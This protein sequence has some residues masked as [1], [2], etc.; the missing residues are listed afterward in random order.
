MQKKVIKRKKRQ[1][2]ARRLPFLLSLFLTIY[3]YMNFSLTL[4]AQD[5]CS[6]RLEVQTIAARCQADGEIICHL[7]DTAGQHLEQIRYSYIPVVGNDSILKTTQSHVNQM[8]PGRYIVSVSALCRTGLGHEDAY[9]IVTDSITDV[10][11]GSTYSI[12]TNGVQ[13]NIFTKEHPFGIIPS[14]ACEPTG[15]VQLVLQKGSF[16]YTVNIWKTTSTDTLFYKTIVFDTLQNFGNDPNRSDYKHYYTIDSLAAGTYMMRCHDGCGY[17][18]P[19]IYASIPEAHLT[20]DVHDFLLRNSSG[21]HDSRNIIVF[22]DSIRANLIINNPSYYYYHNPLAPTFEYRFIN[23]TLS[24]DLDTTAWLPLPNIPINGALYLKDTLSQLSSY[25]ECWMKNITLQYRV[26]SCPD[27]IWSSTYTIYPQGRNARYNDPDYTYESMTPTYFDNCYLYS[28]SQSFTKINNRFLF[29]HHMIQFGAKTDSLMVYNDKAYSECGKIL[30]ITIGMS[31]H[32]YITLPVIRRIYD[33]ETNEVISID[34]AFD[35]S[36]QYEWM[37]YYTQEEH[38]NN[39][40]LIAEITDFHGNPL[41]AEKFMSLIDTSHHGID[42]FRITYD[43]EAFDTQEHY[44]AGNPRSVGLTQMCNDF[45]IGSTYSYIGDTI[46]LIESPENNRYNITAY[47][48]RYM[49]F[50]VERDRFDNLADIGFYRNIYNSVF[51]HPA[52]RMS[53][54]DLPSGEYVWV[55]YHACDRPN[56]TIRQQVV[57]TETPTISEAPQYEIIEECTQLKIIPTAG[58]YTNDGVALETYFQAHIGE[59]FQHSLNSV[60][61]GDTIIIGTPGEY[62][63]TMYALPRNNA[64]LLSDNPCFHIDTLIQ[65]DARTI[66]FDYLLSYVCNEFDSIGFVRA[67]GKYG[68]TPHTYTLY[69]APN[70]EGNI[71]GQNHTG[72]F[73]DLPIHYGQVLSI[74]MRDQCHAHFLTNFIVSDMESI[75]KAWM[76]DDVR[77]TT[78]IEGDTCR[79][80]SISMGDATYHWSGPNEYVHDT[81]NSQFVIPRNE[82]TAGF[83]YVTIEGSGCSVIRDSVH[84]DVIKAPYIY[85]EQDTLVCPGETIQIVATAEGTDDIGYTLIKETFAGIERFDFEHRTNGQKDTLAITIVEKTRFYIAQVSDAR[86]TYSATSDTVVANIRGESILASLHSINDSVCKGEDAQL[87]AVSDALPPYTIQW[88]STNGSQILQSDSILHPGQRSTFHLSNIEQ[89]TA[90]RVQLHATG[91]C[92]FDRGI[93]GHTTMKTG[94]MTIPENEVYRFYDSGGPSRSYPF[95]EN[96]ILTF[97]ASDSTATLTMRFEQ[98]DCSDATG[99]D[100]TDVL[101]IFDGDTI[102]DTPLHTLRGKIDTDHLP[103]ISSSTGSITCWFLSNHTPDNNPMSYNGW[104]AT[105]RSSSFSDASTITLEEEAR[106]VVR[107]TSSDTTFR[108]EIDE[109]ELPF[110]WDGITFSHADTVTEYRTTQ[111]GCDS[112]VRHILNVKVVPACPN[113][114]DYDGNEYVSIRI[115]RYCW[116]QTNLK[117]THYS[118]GRAIPNVMGYFAEEHADSTQNI[119]IFGRLYDWYAAVDT[120]RIDRLASGHKQGICPE[121]WYLPNEEQYEELGEFGILAIRSP[122]YWIT[123]AGNNSTGFSSLPAGYYNG[124]RHRFENLLGE[125]YYWADSD[126]ISSESASHFHTFLACDTL[127]KQQSSKENG[128]SIRCIYDE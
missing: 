72:D 61:L 11:V 37:S 19:Q 46:R 90:V 112:I 49:H 126:L 23:P 48:D 83:Y 9:V 38:R 51:A 122:Y 47:A 4:Q 34:T 111:N 26:R 53:S 116:T 2:E 78:L 1:K 124:L 94:N 32:S 80:Y 121:G 16:P 119:L 18:M 45:I 50:V 88:L 66:E 105:V 110:L 86:C 117:S 115:G 70:G 64:S 118:D 91:T 40:F 41:I 60:Q 36:N 43:W 21:I 89:D 58:G 33:V 107:G 85:L 3:C 28:F 31:M 54:N 65:W 44:C 81:Q 59:N 93:F 22:K 100:S 63:L 128:F 82:S 30:N 73:N 77:A 69:D 52:L 8:R 74:D 76:D 127:K 35:Y 6:I 29:G 67:R 109:N 113:A 39:H 79:L 56:D 10:Q 17:Y 62:R 95:H 87:F 13:S 42:T 5:V 108:Q 27:T 92:P 75:R 57:F 14:L 114:I 7:R 101:F 71:L 104:V 123:N 25:G 96:H 98:F 125:T 120:G 68:I 20:V 12:P 84:L 102:G 15:K 103:T 97:H 55:V 99:S 24:S 106:V